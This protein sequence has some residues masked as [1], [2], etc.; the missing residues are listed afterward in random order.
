MLP[1]PSSTGHRTLYQCDPAVIDEVEALEAER[2]QFFQEEDE[3]VGARCDRENEEVSGC[4]RQKLSHKD[5]I[6]SSG[7]MRTRK[8]YWFYT[9]VRDARKR[10]I[11]LSFPM[12]T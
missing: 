8:R 6:V 4:K 3:D 2:A 10:K 12:H 11:A 5:R 7:A 1:F 9:C